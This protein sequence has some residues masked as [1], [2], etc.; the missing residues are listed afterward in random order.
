MDKWLGERS[1]ADRVTLE[2]LLRADERRD[3]R[4]DIDEDLLLFF[5]RYT[6]QKVNTGRTQQNTY[7]LH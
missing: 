6:M 4:S 1:E 7:S 5:W 3:D 2:C